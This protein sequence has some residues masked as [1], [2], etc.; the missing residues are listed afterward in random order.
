ME[1]RHTLKNPKIAI[2]KMN[3]SLLGLSD[4]NDFAQDVC[5]LINAFR[6]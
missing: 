3:A 4:S 2:L 1:G 6:Y 5:L